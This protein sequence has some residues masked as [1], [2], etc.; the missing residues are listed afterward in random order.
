MR[1][2]TYLT[3]GLLSWFGV[4]FGYAQPTLQSSERF[5]D[6]TIHSASLNRDQ[7]ITVFLPKGYAGGKETYPTLYV[8]DGQF[9]SHHGVAFQETSDWLFL[10]PRFVVIG[11]SSANKQFRG[12]D[13]SSDVHYENYRSFLAKE[14][15]PYVSNN[16]RV[17]KDRLVFGWQNAGSFVTNIL[18]HSPELFSAYL[19]ASGA[20]SDDE[21]FNAFVKRGLTQE[22]F[23]YFAHSPSE[24]WAAQQFGQFLNLVETKAPQLLRWKHETFENED[25]W[26]TPYRTLYRGLSEYFKDYKPLK[27][28]RIQDFLDAGGLEALEHHYQKRAERFNTSPDIH[29]STIFYLLRLA[30]QENDMDLFDQIM[31]HFDGQIP[32]L[33][34]SRWYDRF[35]Q[36][37]IK[38][39]RIEEARKFYEGAISRFPDEPVLFSGLGECYFAQK[40][41]EDA[42]RLTRKALDLAKRVKDPDVKRYED[43]LNRILEHM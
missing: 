43:F 1:L 6:H 14:L 20:V 4:C 9:F 22:R 18:L 28:N 12:L 13:F 39:N 17:S 41:Y 30:V 21:S 7:P 35:G 19:V 2:F 8:L 23:L 10:S 16:Y 38:N 25:H 40:K 26:S 33:Y 34:P 3:F 31:V 32:G 5:I 27:Y 11:I 37:Y 42:E 15:L 29:F 36:F 24:T